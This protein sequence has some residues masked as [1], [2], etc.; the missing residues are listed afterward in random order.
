MKNTL[1][2]SQTVKFE[3][4]KAFI[5]WH[6]EIYGSAVYIPDNDVTY[7]WSL[8]KIYINATGMYIKTDKGVEHL[9]AEEL[10]PLYSA[11]RRGS[12]SE[13]AEFISLQ[14]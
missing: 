12:K 3:T 9:Y 1:T 7:G 10:S 5:P 4:L 13:L 2:K 8:H 11:I 6:E 14:K